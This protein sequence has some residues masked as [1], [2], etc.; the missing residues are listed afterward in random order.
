MPVDESIVLT[1]HISNFVKGIHDH[2]FALLNSGEQ[3]A[4][5]KKYLA[6]GSD[7]RFALT[8]E[9]L[10]KKYGVGAN[11]GNDETRDLYHTILE[12][13]KIGQDKWVSIPHREVSP[14]GL[15]RD[16]HEA[17]MCSI[18]RGRI[19]Q[20]ARSRMEDQRAAFMLN[21][22]DAW[23]HGL[24]YLPRAV[25]ND[26]KNALSN[27]FNGRGFGL[28]LMPTQEDLLDLPKTKSFDDHSSVNHKFSQTTATLASASSCLYGEEGSQ[29]PGVHFSRFV[30]GRSNKDLR[31][32]CYRTS[33]TFDKLYGTKK[34]NNNNKGADDKPEA[35]LASAAAGGE[36]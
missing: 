4:L 10:E 3:S 31:D 23:T 25:Y 2:K 33:P 16:E 19:R 5:N 7:V 9:E 22:R 29:C 15:D 1:K 21:V 34:H 18:A 12:N 28:G 8:I 36:L 26:M 13:T 35:S 6:D 32:S 20:Y 17:I 11:L 30:K 14:A 24:S 27:W